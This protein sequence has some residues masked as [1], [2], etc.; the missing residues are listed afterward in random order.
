[1]NEETFNFNATSSEY[2]FLNRTLAN[3]SIGRV[4]EGEQPHTSMM[5]HHKGPRS[6]AVYD[7]PHYNTE[8][9]HTVHYIT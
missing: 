5:T 6:R 7:C 4:A 1:M 9:S 8:K 3:G 2:A